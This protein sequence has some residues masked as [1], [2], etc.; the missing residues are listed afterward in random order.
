MKNTTNPES[1]PSTSPWHAGE[2]QLQ[3]AYGVAERMAVVGARVIRPFMPDQ[4]R[5]FFA[6]LPFLVYGSVDS[7][8]RPW[9]G[10]L[11]G[12]PGFA[13]SPEARELRLDRLPEVGDPGAEG[14]VAGAAI[15]LLG[16]ELETRRRNRMNGRVTRLDPGGLTVGVDQSFGNCPQYI[17]RREREPEPAAARGAAAA[18]P[19][20]AAETLAGLD[21]EAREGLARADTFFVAS[22]VEGD[23]EGEGNG[24]GDRAGATAD[25]RHRAVDVSHRGGRPGFVRVD[26]DRLTI[27]DF[28]GNLHFNTLGNLV[29][30]P[31]AGLL[32][33]DFESGDLLQLSGR[34]GLVTDPR[35]V[36]AH[37]GAERLWWLD[38]EAA[39]RRRG[40]FGLRYALREVSPKTQATGSWGDAPSRL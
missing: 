11:E 17:Q 8:G 15:G 14:I 36:A 16:I 5:T 30:N 6:G 20:V 32:F 39:V 24:D 38:V 27:P 23:G 29:A 26:G 34:T 10:L 19:R 37:P 22:Y 9:A 1:E 28:S 25:P 31:R 33:V 40:A 13:H 4:H 35:A 18:K 7:A 12:P 3:A 2:R 21:A